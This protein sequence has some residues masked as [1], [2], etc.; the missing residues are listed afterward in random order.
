MGDT[1]PTNGVFAGPRGFTWH[2]VEPA[3]LFWTEAL[4]KGDLAQQGAAPRSGGDAEGAVHALSR[5]KCFKTEWR[6]GGMQ[7]TEKGAVLVT[8]SDRA[9]RTRRTWIYDAGVPGS[10]RK[11]WELPQ[12]DRYRDPGTAGA[13]SVDATGSSRSATASTCRARA[14]RR[15]AIGRSSIAST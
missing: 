14:R 12:E 9:T 1:I 7:F 15:R 5:P 3:T 8:E 11:V 13:P 6:Y 2:A 10:P 4:D